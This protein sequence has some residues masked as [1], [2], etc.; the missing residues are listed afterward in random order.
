MLPLWALAA[1]LQMSELMAL[2]EVR[3]GGSDVGYHRGSVPTQLPCKTVR[4][5]HDDIEFCDL[6]PASLRKASMSLPQEPVALRRALSAEGALSAALR[7]CAQHGPVGACLSS[8]TRLIRA[9]VHNVSACKIPKGRPAS[10]LETSLPHSV[11][12]IVVQVNWHVLSYIAEVPMPDVSPAQADCA[13]CAAVGLQRG[14][15][16]D[17][18]AELD[19]LVHSGEL[20]RLAAEHGPALAAGLTA[21]LTVKLQVIDLAAELHLSHGSAPLTS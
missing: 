21:L 4:G 20:G 8:T 5:W 15:T 12:V 9:Y 18:A 2:C 13:A 7:L 1:H 14:C 6:A 10:D 19:S 11:L 3:V 17:V 16:D